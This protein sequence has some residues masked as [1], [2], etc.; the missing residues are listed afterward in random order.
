VASLS[1]ATAAS[2]GDARAAAETPQPPD[3]SDESAIADDEN[4][5]APSFIQKCNCCQ[6]AADAAAGVRLSACLRC[7]R[8]GYCSKDCQRAHWKA[9]HKDTCCVAR[10]G[11][12]AGPPI[13][14][15]RSGPAQST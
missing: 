11:E 9:G 14:E 8:A 1:E 2:C 5:E 6:A 7:G 15:R 13:S 10:E 4:A 3:A 12:A